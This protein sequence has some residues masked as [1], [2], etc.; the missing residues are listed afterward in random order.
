M[1]DNWRQGV[2]EN[3]TVLTTVKKPP[4]LRSKVRIFSIFVTILCL[5]FSFITFENVN[6][7]QRKLVANFLINIIRNYQFHTHHFQLE[8]LLC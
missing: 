4:H 8:F 1:V 5:A 6:A 2:G 7:R 3:V